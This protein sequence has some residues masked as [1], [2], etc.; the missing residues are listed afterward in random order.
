VKKG[1][2]LAETLIT[3][4]VIGIIMA[5]SIPAVIQ[6]TNDTRPLFKKAYNS[7]EETVSELVN[8]TA[9]YPSGDL[10]SPAS[11][12]FCSNFFSKLNTIGTVSCGN[13]ALT[14][15]PSGV[16]TGTAADANAT[17]AMRWYNLHPPSAFVIPAADTA[18]T[19]ANCDTATTGID[20]TGTPAA[21]LCVKIRVDVNGPNKG[22]SIN[23][24]QTNQDIFD[25]Y[26]T[27][28]GKVTVQFAV[29]AAWDEANIL[30]N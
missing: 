29:A 28:S 16:P 20:V 24:A 5:L 7:V 3:M 4:A 22:A 2:T 25:I 23:S 6:S 9:L 19:T 26:V 27:N 10:S 11:G 17:N 15:F 1:F 8:D 14:T 30:Q 12:N 18:F 13:A 21:N